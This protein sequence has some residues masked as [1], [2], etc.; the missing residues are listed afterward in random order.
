MLQMRVEFYSGVALL[1]TLSCSSNPGST[2]R[3][4]ASG[5]TVTVP[6]GPT[7]TIPAGALSGDTTITVETVPG[8]TPSGA[9][10]AVYKFGPDGTT[11][12]QPVTVT[13]PVIS[14]TTSGSVYWT[15]P[16]SADAYDALSA[17]FAGNT[18]TAHVTHFSQGYVGAACSEGA[19][20]TPSNP[21]K[22]ASLTCSSGAPVC[23][24]LGNV[25]DGISCGGG[26]VCTAG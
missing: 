8:A 4:G 23:T 11:F 12:A 5:G 7:L 10:S 13:F 6:N 20:C 25:S 18:A 1:L 14:G 21:C 19:N 24:D 3:I 2:N 15:R 22:T 9:V 16:G 17:T 26:S